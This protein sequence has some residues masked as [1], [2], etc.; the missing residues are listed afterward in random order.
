CPSKWPFGAS[1][2]APKTPLKSPVFRRW[3]LILAGLI[4]YAQNPKV[5]DMDIDFFDHYHWLPA[6]RPT[7]TQ[8]PFVMR[9]L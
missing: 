6:P 4:T 8:A 1:P 7:L 2:R 3:T 9:Q 5:M